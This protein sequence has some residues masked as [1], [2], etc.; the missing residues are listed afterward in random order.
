M[1]EIEI[2][3]INEGFREILKSQEVAHLVDEQCERIL[4]RCG[5]GYESHSFIGWRDSRYV[6]VV[7]TGD[8]ESCLD[9]AR[10]KTLNMAVGA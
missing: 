1:S 5:E 2:E 6:G 4:A 9:Q 8:F 3:F 7:G 10:N